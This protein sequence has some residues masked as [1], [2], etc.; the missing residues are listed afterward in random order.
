MIKTK[1]LLIYIIASCFIIMLFSS[2]N[3]EFYFTHSAKLNVT[4]HIMYL[5]YTSNMQELYVNDTD[6]ESPEKASSYELYDSSDYIE[7]YKYILYYLDYLNQPEN[8]EFDTDLQSAV[9]KYQQ[10]NDLEVNGKLDT[11]TM[12]A[13][14]AEVI[15]YQIG[16]KSEEI[17]SYQQIL[18]ELNY[19]SEDIEINGTFGEE[20]QQAVEAYQ[21]NNELEVTGV[22]DEETQAAMSRNLYEQ[23]PAE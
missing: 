6:E 17:L 10:L 1:S 13:L 23:I 14:D 18:K 21:T 5:A 4:D 15:E 20:T 8:N 3:A 16:K 2:F 19:L 7:D 12:Q 9:L 11:P 22:L